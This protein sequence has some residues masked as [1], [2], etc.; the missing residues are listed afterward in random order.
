VLV[1]GK[2]A[3]VV[4]GVSMDALTVDVSAIP[5]AN[6]WDEVVIMGTQQDE[7]ITANDLAA[8]KKTVSYDVLTGWRE[9]LPR[10]YVE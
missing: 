9:R 3:P 8:L 2:R 6:Q 1:H 7:T 4:G 5:A 10:S